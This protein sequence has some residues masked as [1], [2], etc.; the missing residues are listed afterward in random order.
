MPA[1]PK[2]APLVYRI[3]FW[4]SFFI[5]M[6]FVVFTLSFL[7]IAVPGPLFLWSTLTDYVT[8]TTNNDQFFQHLARLMMLLFGPLYVILLNAIHDYTS[9]DQRLWVRMSLCFGVMFATLTGINYFVQLSAVRLSIIHGTTRG[10][11]QLVQAN[12]DSLVAAI[13]LLG[14]SVGLGVSS[15]L[16]APVF[17]GNR[18]ARVVRYAFLFN[19]IFCLSGGLGYLLDNIALIFITLNFGLGGAVFTAAGGLCLLFRDGI[20]KHSPGALSEQM[21]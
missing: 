14:W 3:G 11:E 9:P 10:L 6:T 15:L 18:T 21:L 20:R 13:N 5:L 17:S 1:T 7:A 2:V 16:V 8:Y 12:P 4:S 19:G